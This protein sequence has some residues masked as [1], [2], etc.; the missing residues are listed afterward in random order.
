[1][2]S[3]SEAHH[4]P[5]NDDDDDDDD[6]DDIFTNMMLGLNWSFYLVFGRPKSGFSLGLRNSFNRRIPICGK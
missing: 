4:R 6:D 2:Y 5:H 1:V 3:S